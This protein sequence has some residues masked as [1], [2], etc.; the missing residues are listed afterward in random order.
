MG[1]DAANARRRPPEAAV[2]SRCMLCDGGWMRPLRGV[3]VGVSC[4]SL[5]FGAYACSTHPSSSDGAAQ[6]EAG[7]TSDAIAQPADTTTTTM[8]IGPEGG[9]LEV[10]GVRVEIPKGALATPSTL[11]LVVTPSTVEVKPDTAFLVPARVVLSA[12]FLNGRDPVHLVA[13]HR[14]D[15]G[16]D[17]EN[18]EPDGSGGGVFSVLSFTDWF[19]HPYSIASGCQEFDYND[20]WPSLREAA[21]LNRDHLL[22]EATDSRRWLPGSNAV[23][24]G[25]LTDIRRRLAG[26][27]LLPF[28]Q[29]VDM[30]TPP[31]PA[32]CPTPSLRYPRHPRD[33]NEVYLMSTQAADALGVAM[34]IVHARYGG[35]YEI[36][37][38]GALDTYGTPDLDCK[39]VH[40]HDSFHNYGAAVDVSLVAVAVDSCDPCREKCTK[41]GAKDLSKLGDLASIMIEAGF[42]WVWFELLPDHVHASIASPEC[43]VTLSATPPKLPFTCASPHNC[44]AEALACCH[45]DFPPDGGTRYGTVC[46]DRPNVFL[47]QPDTSP[48]YASC[49]A[50]NHCREDQRFMGCFGGTTFSTVGDVCSCGPPGNL[51]AAR[52]LALCDTGVDLFSRK[53]P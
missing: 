7:A 40:E 18:V 24:P 28:D 20:A 53:C 2:P 3:L 36:N 4:L 38:N 30:V 49:S 5:W 46:A 43:G 6:P 15:V 31:G 44:W 37:I 42:S 48:F 1:Y 10:G 22:W 8:D 35:A 47:A 17:F 26:I 45:F 32:R 27:P 52:A 39:G 12:A 19:L 41:K 51:E 50:I 21:V 9:V 33:P 34:K 25:C 14:D 13:F 23:D 29:I 11:T 16:G